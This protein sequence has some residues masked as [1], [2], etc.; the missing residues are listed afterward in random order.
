MNC[1]YDAL[2]GVSP[3]KDCKAIFLKIYLG[4]EKALCAF[5]KFVVTKIATETLLPS[6]SETLNL[7]RY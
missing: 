4:F 6:N 3:K 7:R 1:P 2:L 5:S